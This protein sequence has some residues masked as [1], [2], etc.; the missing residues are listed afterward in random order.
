MSHL[1][2][3]L[4]RWRYTIAAVI[5]GLLIATWTGLSAAHIVPS[6]WRPVYVSHGYYDNDDDGGDG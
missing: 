3:F 4:R 5:L 1:I 2:V 6:G